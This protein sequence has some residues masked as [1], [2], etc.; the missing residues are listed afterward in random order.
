MSIYKLS[1]LIPANWFFE[2]KFAYNICS[3]NWERQLCSHISDN[4]IKG[5]VYSGL[6]NVKGQ[7][8]LRWVNDTT[9]L[10]CFFG[11]MKI[12]FHLSKD[13]AHIIRF[14]LVGTFLGRCDLSPATVSRK[15]FI[16]VIFVERRKA[17]SFCRKMKQIKPPRLRFV[18]TASL[19]ALL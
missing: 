9:G 18:F 15:Y 4:P 16:F 12:K 8:R 3:F 1:D 7:R 2:I 14:H 11:N 19:W 5:V 6:I 13:S 10:N 17:D